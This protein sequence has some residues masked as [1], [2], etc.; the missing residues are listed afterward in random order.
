M[1][2]DLVCLAESLFTDQ[3]SALASPKPLVWVL[4]L[5][6]AACWSLSGFLSLVL[7]ENL[8]SFPVLTCS[9]SPFDNWDLVP[10]GYFK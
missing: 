2:W 1:L 8:V 6:L 4:L 10:R 3:N 5:L 9:P 7:V